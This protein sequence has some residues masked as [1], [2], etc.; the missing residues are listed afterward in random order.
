MRRWHLT[1]DD[2]ESVVWCPLVRIALA[3]VVKHGGYIDDGRFI[4]AITNRS[5]TIVTTVTTN[6]HR[7]G[8]PRRAR[9]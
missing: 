1:R 2:V 3:R 4:V 7:R 9:R 8:V 6:E 5:E